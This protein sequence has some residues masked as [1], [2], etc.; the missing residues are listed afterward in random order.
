[1]SAYAVLGVS[2]QAS[3]DAVRKAWLDKARQLHPDKQGSTEEFQELQAAYESICRGTAE[4]AMQPRHQEDMRRTDLMHWA[5]Q[6]GN[7][8]AS[9]STSFS[10]E[11]VN[12]QDS[13]GRTALMLAAF[14]GNVNAVRL[15]IEQ[16]ADLDLRNCGG[17][18]ALHFAA[19]QRECL[20]QL[21]QAG[22]DVNAA[23]CYGLSSLML[24]AA[25]GALECI[26]I[27]LDA[28]ADVDA[29][30]DVGFTALCMAADKGFSECVKTLIDA[31]AEVNQRFRLGRTP[32]MSAAAAGHTEVVK[33]L[34]MGRAD[35]EVKCDRGMK[36]SDYARTSQTDGLLCPQRVK[37]QEGVRETLASVSER[38]KKWW[39]CCICFSQ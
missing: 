37:E 35:M 5:G 29:S 6:S 19:S 7:H 11:D 17:H 23:T 12:E 9:G 27:L 4:Q 25:Q 38:R 31:K 18:S 15:L 28:K 10:F 24:S 1:M 21:I 13:T 22:A 34:L 33:L 32:L 16:N 26:E 20:R 8:G 3:P 2:E 30:S 14:V 39:H 36:A